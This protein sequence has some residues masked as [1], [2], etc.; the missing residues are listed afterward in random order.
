MNP[1]VAVSKMLLLHQPH[2]KVYI[3]SNGVLLSHNVQDQGIWWKCGLI[4]VTEVV[5][6][7]CTKE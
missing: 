2:A 7:I 5:N 6:D 4:L 1:G 3:H